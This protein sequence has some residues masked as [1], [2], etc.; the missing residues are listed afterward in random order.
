[1]AGSPRAAPLARWAP[2]QSGIALG[3]WGVQGES[4][5]TTLRDGDGGAPKAPRSQS[6]RD[7]AGAHPTCGRLV[8]V[9]G[10]E[11]PNP[12][13]PVVE[14]NRAGDRPITGPYLD[15]ARPAGFEPT[16]PWFVAKYSIQLSY[17]REGA[18]CSEIR[19]CALRLLP[20]AF[21][22]AC[23]GVVS[24][25]RSQP[26]LRRTVSAPARSPKRRPGRAAA[27]PARRC[28]HRPAGSSPAPPP[29]CD[30][31]PDRSR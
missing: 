4:E 2:R 31:R 21:A 26:R 13:V 30:R 10:H 27:P 17:G 20:V 3:R 14:K 29:A 7:E 16:T 19:R 23:S 8:R 28:C 6:S 22:K 5:V 9:S 12:R 15:V 11:G 1:M 24:T 25:A 18:Q